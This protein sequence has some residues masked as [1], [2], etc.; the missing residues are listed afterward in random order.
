M[1]R[2]GLKRRGLAGN[3]QDVVPGRS[4]GRGRK[5]YTAAEENRN[6]K[7]AWGGEAGRA[8][9]SSR[10]EGR[11]K[12]KA[13]G[14]GTQSRGSEEA[15]KR[16]GCYREESRLRRRRRLVRGPNNGKQTEQEGVP[17]GGAENGP[18]R[19]STEPA[20]PGL[21]KDQ[22]EGASQEGQGE[23]SKPARPVR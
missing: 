5:E 21:F 19:R 2:V 9:Y 6:A 7:R 12:G 23:K 13:K 14:R 20:G 3:D 10:K 1:D 16:W 4:G 17:L 8:P 11:A 18:N 22:R 15:R